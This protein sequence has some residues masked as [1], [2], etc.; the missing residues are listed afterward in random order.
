MIRTRYAL[1]KLKATYI[2]EMVQLVPRD[3][4]QQWLEVV[5]PLLNSG[6]AGLRGG[7]FQLLGP[8][9]QGLEHTDDLTIEEM[10]ALNKIS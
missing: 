5:L 3:F 7:F 10:L 6:N 4:F 8:I 2:Q 9:V 1:L